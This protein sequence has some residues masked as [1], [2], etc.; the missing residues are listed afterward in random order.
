MKFKLNIM[1]CLCE[2]NSLLNRIRGK[3][4]THILV[5]NTGQ[6]IK[7]V[8]SIELF[9]GEIKII[10]AKCQI[11]LKNHL[12]TIYDD[13]VEYITEPYDDKTWNTIINMKPMNN[14]VDIENEKLYYG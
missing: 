13:N 6:K 5:T 4:I 3:E 14:D 8:E 9:E 10:V 2:I 7:C 11:G 12:I 1:N